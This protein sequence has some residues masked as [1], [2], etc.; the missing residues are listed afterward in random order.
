MINKLYVIDSQTKCYNTFILSENSDIDE[1]KLVSRDDSIQN[2][3]NHQCQNNE[4]NLS[5]FESNNK[6]VI[7]I[8]SSGLSSLKLCSTFNIK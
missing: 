6:T 3:F 8:S 2:T 7:N 4:V 5:I 1:I